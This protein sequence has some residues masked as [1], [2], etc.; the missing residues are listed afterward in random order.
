MLHTPWN[1][2]PWAGWKAPRWGWWLGAVWS[3][4]ALGS[5]DVARLP[6]V[7]RVPESS[8]LQN[9]WM[10][11]RMDDKE[12][13]W[14]RQFE[15]FQQKPGDSQI[16]ILHLSNQNLYIL[17]DDVE[18]GVSPN[19]DDGVLDLAPT[20]PAYQQG[21]CINHVASWASVSSPVQRKSSGLHTLEAR[22]E[23]QVRLSV[24]GVP[25]AL[26]HGNC[27]KHQGGYG[28]YPSKHHF[29]GR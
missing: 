10:T 2:R 12:R 7:L 16:L 22:C 29:K 20:F 1:P 21:P 25:T 28:H 17:G 27:T 8:L 18:V 11:S 19:P 15:S 13:E 3:Q 14:K 24:S 4:A 26:T 9:K 6:P 5:G 23:H